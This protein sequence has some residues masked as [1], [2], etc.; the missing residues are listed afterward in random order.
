MSKQPWD[1]HDDLS[2][3]RLQLLAKVLRDTRRDAVALHDPAAGDT[4]WSLGCRVYARSTEMLSRTAD[5]LWPWLVVVQSSLEFVFKIGAVPLR[6][7][8]GDASRPDAQHLKVAEVEARQ[9]GFAFGDASADLVWRIVVETNAAGEA[10]DIVLIGSTSERDVECQFV[11]PR[12]DD[13]VSFL[14][15]LKPEG[16][17][18]VELPSPIITPRRNR[19]AKDEDGGSEV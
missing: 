6:F 16:G 17:G 12:L 19:Q 4:S 15:P 18:G 11:I 9:L 1:Y 7:F 13:S 8:H 14:E 5:D 10:E 2:L 3:D